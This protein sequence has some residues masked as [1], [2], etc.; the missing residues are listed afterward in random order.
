[1]VSVFTPENAFTAC[2][3]ASGGKAVVLALR[4]H[5]GIYV[6]HLTGGGVDGIDSEEDSKQ[7]M[8]GKPELHGKVVELKDEDAR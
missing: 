7:I 3:V 8:F 4:G 6:L 2:E 1:L 5:N